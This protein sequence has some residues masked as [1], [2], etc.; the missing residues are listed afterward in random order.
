MIFCTLLISLTINFC[1]LTEQKGLEVL[2]S[3]SIYSV[4][5][6]EDGAIWIN[7][8]FGIYR[9]N[10]RQLS[11]IHEPILRYRFAR[12]GDG[13][14][15]LCHQ[16]SDKIYRIDTRTRSI[17]EGRGVIPQE[18]FKGLPW[19]D[20][21]AVAL[22]S[23]GNRYA[24]TVEGLFRIS[25]TGITDE[26]P[27]RGIYGSPICD[28]MTDRDG[29]LW[30]GTFYDGLFYCNLQSNPFSHISKHSRMHKIKGAVE[31]PDSCIWVT[32]DGYGMYRK[33]LG[34]DWEEVPGTE[35]IK[36][37]CAIYDA[38]TNSLWAGEFMGR[39]IHYDISTGRL[40]RIPFADGK[41]HS[42]S[43]ICRVGDDLFIGGEGGVTMLDPQREKS[44]GR[45]INEV[46]GFVNALASR[47][48]GKLWIGSSRIYEYS[49]D[50]NIRK[51][52]TP[53]YSI[54]DISFDSDG[55]LWAAGTSGGVIRL[56]T[57]GVMST[58]TTDNSDLHDNFTNGVIPLSSG[59]IL[60]FTRSGVEILN[61][62]T[63][64]SSLFDTDEGA[65]TLS[66]DKATKLWTRDGKLMIFGSENIQILDEG[67]ISS[68]AS[69]HLAFDG[70][71]DNRL[72]IRPEDRNFSI[73]LTDF[74]YTGINSVSYSY[75]MSGM[76]SEWTD[77][78]ISRPLQFMNMKPGRY[79]LII[80]GKSG[81]DVK[82][83]A[84]LNI[85]I[86]PKWHESLIARIMFILAA[87]AI[88]VWFIRNA[89]D[90][91]LMGE[92]L[93]MKDRENE[94]KVRQFHDISLQLRTPVNLILTDLEQFFR[95]HGSH[96]RGI[97]AIEEIYARTRKMHQ[98]IAGYVENQENIESQ[99]ILKHERFLS[100]ATAVVER[101]L[102]SEQLNVT[103]LCT[104]LHMGKSKLSET[105]RAA[106]GMSPREFIEDIRL[107]HGQ[108]M[109]ESGIYR[110]GE[111]AERLGFSNA[112]YFSQRYRR[113]FGRSP[114]GR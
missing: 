94:D 58:F 92:K 74:N 86:L 21:R 77:F 65:G 51:F 60:V 9:F 10:G 17:S 31:T 101:N 16:S 76:D 93:K 98:L 103:T 48:D 89:Y 80:K 40:E 61:P 95:E 29:N 63:G 43:A 114:K 3:S 112:K 91:A 113:K 96:T 49:S 72:E 38:P 105:M 75:I 1:S 62:E 99:I 15:V 56:D 81:T 54:A 13:D 30:I 11:W 52:D 109:L 57:S 4:E 70:I 78:D 33:S 50:G 69:Y 28:L 84:S 39:I 53:S 19:K 90:R 5:Q 79:T 73:H 42:V 26:I 6:S 36:F 2:S 32:T 111:V 14:L 45:K 83:Q 59:K 44:A 35:H 23:E 55:V 102:Y 27:I 97:E 25:P 107:R 106:S 20:I 66:T 41:P 46:K 47:G 88:T 67:K 68:A 104:E 87:L 34:G 18:N 64:A 85:R 24:G 7:S 71:Y 110:V 12:S 22:D 108:Q 8:N 82:C 37:Q 100:A